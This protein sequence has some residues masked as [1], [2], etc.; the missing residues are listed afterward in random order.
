MAK[1]KVS[2]FNI[3]KKEATDIIRLL[4][5]GDVNVPVNIEWIGK[6]DR[7]SRLCVDT[8]GKTHIAMLGTAILAK[9]VKPTVN[10]YAFKPKHAKGIPNAYSAR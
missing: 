4:W 1:D 7:L 10:I 8:L 3:S 5:A 2:Q 6:I 9:A